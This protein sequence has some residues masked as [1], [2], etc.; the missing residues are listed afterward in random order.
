MPSPIDPYRECGLGVPEPRPRRPSDV[1][2]RVSLLVLAGWTLLRVASC[3]L[4]G[5]LDGE[6]AAA[7]ALL[8]AVLH[9]IAAIAPAGQ[10]RAEPFAR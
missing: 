8:A 4:C 1:E 6:G 9:A 10:A 2:L 3:V 7:G 5:R